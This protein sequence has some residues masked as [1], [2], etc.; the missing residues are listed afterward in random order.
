MKY[1][2]VGGELVYSTCSLS[3]EENDEVIDKFLSL[4]SN[5]KGINFLTEFGTPFGDY[6]ATILPEHFNSDGFFI[7]KIVKLF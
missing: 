6:K 4:N 3:K 5:F 2:K 7:S 1:L